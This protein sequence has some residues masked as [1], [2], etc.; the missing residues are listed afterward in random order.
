MQCLV[1]G[2]H[3][4][5]SPIG[6]EMCRSYR[7]QPTPDKRLPLGMAGPTHHF[8][9]RKESA[10]RVD[11]QN[12]QSAMQRTYPCPPMQD[13]GRDTMCN[14]TQDRM[15]DPWQHMQGPMQ[16]PMQDPKLDQ[17][18]DP[19][20]HTQGPMQ[21]P[22]TRAQGPGW[23]NTEASRLLGSTVYLHGCP[24][25][26]CRCNTSVVSPFLH[27]ENA[28]H[29]C[30]H[31]AMGRTTVYWAKSQA[32]TMIETMS[33]SAFNIDL[34]R[35]MLKYVPMCHPYGLMMQVSRLQAPAKLISKPWETRP[36]YSLVYSLT[37]ILEACLRRAGWKRRDND[38]IRCTTLGPSRAH[39][40]RRKKQHTRNKQR[41]ERVQR[42]YV[43]WKAAVMM[44]DATSAYKIQEKASPTGTW[45]T[46]VPVFKHRKWGLLSKLYKQQRHIFQAPHGTHTIK[47]INQLITGIISTQ[48]VHTNQ[49][50]IGGGPAAARTSSKKATEQPPK[51]ITRG[52]IDDALLGELQMEADWTYRF[53]A[54][55]C[56]FDSLQKLTGVPSSAIRELAVQAMMKALAGAS[57]RAVL[58][59]GDILTEKPA[60]IGDQ[61]HIR[62]YLSKKGQPAIASDLETWADCNIAHWGAVAL[63]VQVIAYRLDPST[64]R[65]TKTWFGYGTASI[66]HH[67]VFTGPITEGHYTPLHRAGQ[68]PCMA[69]P[70]SAAALNQM[71]TGNQPARAPADETMLLAL[72]NNLISNVAQQAH[73]DD[74]AHIQRIT[75]L[76]KLIYPDLRMGQDE[77]ERRVTTLWDTPNLERRGQRRQWRAAQAR[78][79]PLEHE[80]IDAD[81][82][83]NDDHMQ[84]EGLPLLPP[85]P[86]KQQSGPD[87]GRE[88]EMDKLGKKQQKHKKQERKSKHNPP[89]GITKITKF[90]IPTPRGS[91][92]GL[93]GHPQEA[94]GPAR[95]TGAAAAPLDVPPPTL[96][97]GAPA[98]P[99]PKAGAPA[100]P[101]VEPP[102]AASAASMTA[103]LAAPSAAPPAA[104]PMPLCWPALQDATSPMPPARAP[105]VPSAAP[106]ALAPAAADDAAL[107]QPPAKKQRTIRDYLGALM[108]KKQP[109]DAPETPPQGETPAQRQAPQGA[110]PKGALPRKEPSLQEA[111]NQKQTKPPKGGDPQEAVPPKGPALTL[112]QINTQGGLRGARG[113]VTD[114]VATHNPSVISISE[115]D[116]TPGPKKKT[117]WINSLLK[118]YKVFLA[119][120]EGD[121]HRTLLAI[122]DRYALLGQATYLKQRNSSGTQGRVA[123]VKLHFPHS[124]P[125]IL[126]SVYAPAGDT[127]E[128][129]KVRSTIYDHLAEHR[130]HKLI[131]MGDMNAAL[132]ATDRAHTQWY[133]RDRAHQAFV[134][135]HQLHP[136]PETDP[137]TRPHSWIGPA[138]RGGENSPTTSRIDDILTSWPI[139]RSHAHQEVRD[140]GVLSDHRPITATIT[141]AALDGIC[142]PA[143]KPQVS[144]EPRQT[145]VRPISKDDKQRIQAAFADPAN[146]VNDSVQYMLKT[147]NPLVKEAQ[148]HWQRTQNEDGKIPNKLLTLGGQ[149]AQEVIEHLGQ[150]VTGNLQ[151]YN[152]IAHEEGT[153]T[154]NNPQGKHHKCKKR[155]KDREAHKAQLRTFREVRLSSRLQGSKDANAIGTLIQEHTPTHRNQSPTPRTQAEEGATA[156]RRL[157]AWEIWQDLCDL[158]ENKEVAA[159]KLLD[160]V[161]QE[162]K[163]QIKQ[164][165][166][167]DR[168]A[169][170]NVGKQRQRELINKHP[171]RANQQIF[172]KASKA[173][174][175]KVLRDPRTNM[176]TDDPEQSI[177]IVEEQFT[178]NQRSPTGK[179][180]G[181]YLDTKNRRYPWEK[182]GAPDAFK[183]CT[184][185]TSLA[186]RPG[187]HEVIQDPHIFQEC[188]E[189]LA[190]GKAAGPD[191][192][193]NEILKLLPPAALEVIHKYFI[194][195]WATGHTPTQWKESYTIL[196]F[197]NKG[198]ETE[199]SQY[200][201][202]GLL[203]T[204]YKLWT[205]MLTRALSDYAE[206]HS[207]L[208][209]SQKGFRKAANTMHQ[210][211]M[212]RMA[213]EDARMTGQN[214]FNLQV[215]F[216][217]A[218]NMMD[219]DVLL[220][221]MQDLGFPTDAI[222]VIK[223]LYTGATTQVKWDHG[224]TSPIPVDRGSIQGDSLS[225]L[226]FLIYIEPLL[227]WLHVGAKGYMFGCIDKQA[228]RITHHL[229]SAAYADDLSILTSKVSDLKIQAQKLSEFSTWAHLPVNIGKTMVTGVLYQNIITQM[230]GHKGTLQQVR[231]Q[232]EN[233]ILV[234]GQHIQYQEPTETFTYLGAQLTMTLDPRPQH[235]AIMTKLR[236]AIQDLEESYATP[237]QIRHI[238]KTSI[239]PSIS[240]TLAITPCTPM[241]LKLMDNQI[242][243]AMKKAYSLPKSAPTAMVHENEENYGLGCASIATQYAQKGIAALVESLRE[244]GRMGVVTKAILE[245]QMRYMGGDHTTATCK[246]ELPY[247]MRVRQYALAVDSGIEIRLDGLPTL[248][249]ATQVVR[250]IRDRIQ[251][252]L[253]ARIPTDFMLPLYQLGVTHFGDLLEEASMKPGGH[254]HLISGHSLK[255]KFSR[256]RRKVTVR[257]IIALNQLT[258]LLGTHLQQDVDIKQLLRI[259]PKE[260]RETAKGVTERMIHVENWSLMTG[261]TANALPETI[262][263]EFRRMHPDQHLITEYTHAIPKAP[264]EHQPEPPQWTQEDDPEFLRQASPR[265][266]TREPPRKQRRSSKRKQ[267]RPRLDRE[268][269][270]SAPQR[271]RRQEPYY[272]HGWKQRQAQQFFEGLGPGMTDAER[273]ASTMN[274]LHGQQD[275][276]AEILGWRIVKAD[277]SRAPSAQAKGRGSDPAGPTHASQIQQEVRWKPTY[278]ER[279][280]L[281]YHKMAGYTP[282]SQQPCTRAQLMDEQFDSACEICWLADSHHMHDDETCTHHPDMIVCDTCSKTFHVSCLGMTGAPEGDWH[283]PACIRDPYKHLED[284]M[285]RVE[286]EPTWEPRARLET[287]VPEM[288]TK[289]HQEN[290]DRLPARLNQHALDAHLD[291]LHRQ[292][293]QESQWQSTLG[294]PIRNKIH[295]VTSTVNPQADIQGTG[296]CRIEIRQ[297]HTMA[298]GQPQENYKNPGTS[299]MACVYTPEGSC[300]HMCTVDRLAILRTL[301]STAQAEGM[302]DDIQPAVQSFETEVVS[303]CMRSK[304]AHKAGKQ[305]LA[306][307]PKSE[308]TVHPALWAALMDHIPFTKERFAS[309][310]NVTTHAL[311]YWSLHAR[312][313]VFGARHNAY[314]C[315]WTGYSLAHPNRDAASMAKALTWAV[316][317]A[318]ATT[319]PVATLLVV[320]G[321]KRN[322]HAAYRSL[323]QQHKAHCE[324][325]ATR[326]ARDKTLHFERA[327]AHGAD[328][329]HAPRGDTDLILVS[330]AEARRRLFEG[331]ATKAKALLQAL[332][333]TRTRSIREGALIGRM[334]AADDAV[335]HPATNLTHKFRNKAPDTCNSMQRYP[336]P[337]PGK[338]IL[339]AHRSPSP[340]LHTWQDIAYTDGSILTHTTEDGTAIKGI[341][342][343]IYHPSSQTEITI[344]P[345]CEGRTTTINRAELAGIWAALKRGYSNI[346]T[347]SASS[348]AQIRK[349]ILQPMLMG[350]HKHKGLVGEVVELI[351]AAKEPITIMKIKAHN[352]H[353]GNEGADAVAKRAATQNATAETQQER[354]DHMRVHTGQQDGRTEGYWA[355]DKSPGPNGQ[356]KASQPL[357]NLRGQLQ[358]VVHKRHK[359]GMANTESVYYQGWQAIIPQ[360]DGDTS[361]AF[362]KDTNNITESQRTT[363]L[364]LRTGTLHN[365]KRAKW[366]GMA[367]T[368][369]CP[370]C[371]QPDSGSHIAG[372]CQHS[373][374][375]KMYSERH[376]RAGRIILK[377][378]KKGSKGG[379][380]C[381]ADL[382]SKGRCEAA[383]AP[384]CDTNHIP[385]SVFP[386]PKGRGMKEH[387]AKIRTL[388]PDL[389]LISEEA[390][391]LGELKF[392]ADT[393]PQNQ[394]D[395]ALEQHAE[396]KKMLTTAGRTVT[397]VP[398]LVGN[399]GT[400]YNTHTMEALRKL[401]V[402][403]TQAK[404]CAKKL[405]LE[406]IR[407]LHSIVMTRRHLEHQNTQKHPG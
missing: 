315:Q 65:L 196:L 207:I 340:P 55:D 56:Y 217:M 44:H 147:L 329:Q 30:D 14:I 368:D 76:V 371:R 271:H 204:V 75:N 262:P 342:A 317:S 352:Q 255:L 205:K 299:E 213:L 351:K 131:I 407:S 346:A 101:S 247:C 257:H 162:V 126:A 152:Q 281:K 252:N 216:S 233:Q 107:T 174:A 316:Q 365:Q 182:A 376:N 402:G 314:T 69:R 54:G 398:I 13:P 89:L 289:W 251:P 83:G 181:E 248:L 380:L 192:V 286:W 280:A 41:K 18:Q 142:L 298:A 61:A 157:S 88:K 156:L 275:E 168:E 345:T 167:Q 295:L 85:A 116:I 23:H 15:Q 321:G 121:C 175:H 254:P 355:F 293:F 374:M 288:L 234:Q 20:Q 159:Q 395:R 274:Q 384:V 333:S 236:Q 106:T 109:K 228:D 320:P 124:A 337:S 127:A 130:Q 241:D 273:A 119:E 90:L 133:P 67:L 170:H 153:T 222:E 335:P 393:R 379:T 350:T 99:N 98:S 381:S 387:M 239:I 191:G 249:L 92:L 235:K 183:L 9:R 383:G 158:P 309:P 199:L 389:T 276:V 268:Q 22:I 258:R 226:L 343:G 64:G 331:E 5:T 151:K 347:D 163:Q 91:L 123:A 43:H 35:S 304:S 189:S 8:S 105:D 12:T 81:A 285:E 318:K 220:C 259:K 184:G 202:V 237:R 94:P 406:A 282:S 164:G 21:D 179:K 302:H 27:W 366:F 97:T 311:E 59:L 324:L 396:T 111:H 349:A 102:A 50:Q 203:N 370:L 319:D 120:P 231:A 51:N 33:S 256:I 403:T 195:M 57:E 394:M 145:L 72:I 125:L 16:D 208:S 139:S 66:T 129:L 95:Q 385:I 360:T 344:D 177:Q 52:D 218:F 3:T 269:I 272:D 227:R 70:V 243:R 357:D 73:Q 378:V 100:V 47:R 361:N 122:E 188:R 390:T 96:Q 146:G 148:A 165:D 290:H 37:A 334:V 7:S 62:T 150:S 187:L 206:K 104:R 301:F 328:Q 113:D 238:I 40:T 322:A 185:A 31:E 332:G 292:G 270:K 261:M 313:K 246:R 115:A 310:L 172:N 42:R 143:N 263:E 108:G 375:R 209:S 399:S 53:L 25:L 308:C 58:A 29:L 128:E 306:Q 11:P 364:K 296:T 141:P 278:I 135:K 38:K 363:A 341:G 300:I 266:P 197:K 79:R 74:M 284:P 242:T 400:I 391:I 68:A 362:M 336:S 169:A 265:S 26:A 223:D 161:I 110:P 194:L 404:G 356:P 386:C 327:W 267:P 330:N 118:G 225:P 144:Q 221:T 48:T 34:Y 348:L 358:K 171:K 253:A 71:E 323:Q 166:Q 186:R 112:L 210:L 369:L 154:M 245:M 193:S 46:S 36:V 214:I 367:E 307:D 176:L 312:D 294:D 32:D 160:R 388:K 19:R 229:S 215:D 77:I 155:K 10:L 103:T 353:P 17:G 63:S 178:R 2:L 117:K 49:S 354:D 250:N 28:T 359:T 200:R 244:P 339:A 325:L 132:T 82:H 211:Q 291:D 45:S 201:P 230:Y 173:S 138:A 373:T 264:R 401:G 4:Q 287:L 6:K 338:D 303:L 1:A 136:L 180:S 397:M 283:C 134:K 86:A 80:N 60:H 277:D 78:P 326:H 140:E 39:Q 305:G 232:L 260:D 93:D 297:V 219:H 212:L 137:S 377:A 279:W 405:H 224:I 190:S 198:L 87:Q 240:Y 114:L 84:V 372:G 382:G 24:M 392:C 149:P